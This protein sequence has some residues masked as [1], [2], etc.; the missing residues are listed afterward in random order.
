M[1]KSKKNTDNRS[2]DPALRHALMAEQA[3]FFKTYIEHL[4]LLAEESLQ[5]N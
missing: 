1:R 2:L 5:E 4:K 3:Y